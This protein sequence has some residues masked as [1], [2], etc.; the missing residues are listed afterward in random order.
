MSDGLRLLTDAL[1][2]SGQWANDNQGIVSLCIFLVTIILGWS[3]GIFGALRRRPVFKIRAIDGPTLCCTYSVGREHAGYPVH[4]TAVS[5]YLHIANTGSAP[6]SI[7][8]VWIGYH[9]ALIPFSAEWLR[10]SLG[11]CWLKYAT[12]ALVD[13]QSSLGENTQVYPFLFQRNHLL[14]TEANT[15]LQPGSSVNG[16]MYFESAQNWGGN[17]PRRHNDTVQIKVCITDAYGRK[18]RALLKNVRAVSLEQARRFNP[19][20]GNTHEVHNGYGP[21]PNDASELFHPTA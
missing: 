13:F 2:A 5:L 21:I 7:D 3:S 4:R 8:D 15:Y 17:F 16:I 20:F 6:S 18:H 12:P 9:W 19:Q 11:W 1:V 14:Q 10:Y